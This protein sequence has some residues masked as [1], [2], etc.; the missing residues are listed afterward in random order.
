[1]SQ[2]TKI[3]L[4]MVNLFF[5]LMSSLFLVSCKL[6]IVK[7]KDPV[8]IQDSIF[9]DSQSNRLISCEGINLEGKEAESNEKYNSILEIKIVNPQNL[10]SD[11][12]A[13]KNL[14]KKIASF[15]KKC[16]KDSEEYNI[17]R[18]IYVNQTADGGVIKKSSDKWQFLSKEL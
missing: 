9:I 11:K 10:S 6:T 7:A 14:S 18:V 4:I 1:M 8:F 3:N 15:L 5:F 17:Y 16:L 12:I 13:I 2:K